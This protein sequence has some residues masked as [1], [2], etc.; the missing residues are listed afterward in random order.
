[1]SVTPKQIVIYKRGNELVKLKFDHVDRTIWATQ[2]QIAEVFGVSPQSIT[3]HL[4]KIYES[5]ELN[6]KVTCKEDLQVQIEGGREVKRRLKF[7]NLD[8]IISIG[9]R[10][11]SRQATD[12]RIWSTSVLKQYIIDGFAINQ[13]RLQE[14]NKVLEIVARSDNAEISG[15]AHVLKSYTRALNII[16]DYDEKKLTAPRG[17]KAKWRLTYDEAR[18]L[19]DSIDFAKEN[20]NFAKERDGSF[21]GAVEAIY[22]TFDGKDLY[23]TVQE[24]AA[25]LLYLITKDHSFFDGNKRSAAA[26]FV[27]FLDRNNILRD[28]G[29]RQIIANN[30]L[31]AITLL[32]A[33][34]D[35]SEKSQIILLIMN[36]IRS[37]ND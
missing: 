30:A 16:S 35:P 27:Y 6:E 20:P 36:L 15:V 34:S 2:S 5:R 37:N 22:Q 21:K 29:G 9:Y 32:V 26:L 25:N 24:K 18:R 4:R 10:I 33:L 19:L 14:L 3:I 12:F 11:N 8:A 23:P 13:K 7:Y 31:A 17:N 28:K 1:M